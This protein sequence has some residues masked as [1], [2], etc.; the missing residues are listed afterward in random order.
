MQESITGAVFERA[1]EDSGAVR[2]RRKP[3]GWLTVQGAAENN[4]KNID[5][6][7]PLGVIDLRHRRFRFGK[8]L[9][10]Q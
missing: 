8:E 3:T 6:E 5:V 10:G 1:H 2:A 9:A 4:L 7:F